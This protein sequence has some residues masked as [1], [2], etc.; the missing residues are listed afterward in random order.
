MVK[1]LKTLLI[2]VLAFTLAFTFTACKEDD[3]DSASKTTGDFVYSLEEN[4]DGD[5]Y[6]RITG[7]TVT[8]E[9]A[10][11]MAQ[12]DFREIPSTAREI[13]IPATGRD[14]GENNDYPVEEISAAAFADQ[15]ILTKVNVP[16][17]VKTIGEGAF[18]GCTNLRDL[19]VPFVGKSEDAVG[20]ARVMGYLFGA[21]SSGEGVTEVK[22]KVNKED[23]SAETIYYV[24]SSLKN[25]TVTGNKIPECAFYGFSMLQNVICASAQT[26]GAYA[27][28]GCSQ[29]TTPN[30]TSVTTIYD[31][32]FENCTS[33]QSVKFGDDLTFIGDSAFSGCAAL[34]LNRVSDEK[35]HCQIVLPAS[36]TYLGEKA[37]S[38]CIELKYI[39][40]SN[41]QITE[42]GTATFADNVS[43]KEVTVNANI[44]I[45][46]GA[47]TGCDRLEENL[48]GVDTNKIEIG[49]FGTL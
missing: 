2:S 11:K 23:A 37:F 22:A 31:G 4:E 13:T 43:L 26:I 21:S 25:V 16:A 27:F 33:M 17:T 47:F 40:L 38:N 32:A 34:G 9:D 8:S 24:P 7:Y 19:T 39:D 49:A 18:T 41:T 36:V 6:Y 28:S 20:S 42:I 44:Y 15:I 29:L 5:K 3:G 1:L 45:R 10:L 12:G 30:L 14:L 48:V 35:A 46:V